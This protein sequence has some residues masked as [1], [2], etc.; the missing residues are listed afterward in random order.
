M[1]VIAFTTLL[2]LLLAG[3]FLTW[4]IGQ[5]E[6]YSSH[7]ARA[8]M[9]ADSLLHGARLP[10]LYD[11]SVDLQKPPLY[12]VLVAAVAWMRGGVD[13]TAV[14]LPAALAGWGII[15]LL[16]GFAWYI[17]RPVVGLFASW[18]LLIGIH[19]P[20]LARIGRIDM[21]LAFAVTL[22]SLSFW[23]ALR[24]QRGW[25][26]LAYAGIALGVLL[27]GP[28]GWVLPMV[29]LLAWLVQQ[30]RWPVGLGL[31]PGL[32]GVTLLCAPVYLWMQNESQGRFFHEF[33]WLHNVQRGLGGSRLR[34]HP[35]WLYGPYVFLYLLPV[36]PLLVLGSFSRARREELGRA[37][38]L[39]L[40]A[41][42][43]LLSLARFKRADYLLPAYPGAALFLGVLLER[44]Y[45]RRPLLVVAGTL[46]AI[47][48]SWTA[49]LVYLEKYLPTEASY[50]D[51]QA[52]AGVI[53]DQ[54]SP[55]PVI[56]FQAEAHALMFRVGQPAQVLLDWV[57]LRQAVRQ[58]RLVVLPSR[59]LPTFQQ[60]FP[61]AQV[62]V[63]ADTVQLAG[64]RHE[65]PLTLVRVYR[66][67]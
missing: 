59:L 46:L 1:R 26:V 48:V 13:A 4:G 14:R 16:L 29:I 9:N 35:W 63:L 17:G 32:V 51:Y 2:T 7:E 30:R 49:W 53:R 3:L 20:W 44:W 61:D 10:Q 31:F 25:L 55:E 33:L 22:S 45:T 67:S 43:L 65:R 8:A 47:G 52:L 6:L 62:S 56:Y 21:P 15:A 11:G 50:R 34:A 58:P 27:K 42:V 38:L 5:R 66:P 24:G 18:S 37:G 41:T 40:A 36:T 64:G 12:Y 54:D 60:A 39:W 57:E 19:F 28:I 23:L